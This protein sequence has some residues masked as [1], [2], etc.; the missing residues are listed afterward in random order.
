MRRGLHL[1]GYV[2]KCVQRW[3]KRLRHITLG[4]SWLFL[5]QFRNIQ[6]NDPLKEC[7]FCL[8]WVNQNALSAF[9]SFYY[10]GSLLSE[11]NRH[12]HWSF[13]IPG[14]IFFSSFELP[15]L[16]VWLIYRCGLYMGVEGNLWM[17]NSLFNIKWFSSDKLVEQMQC[18]SLVNRYVVLTSKHHEGWT[19]WRSNVSWNW[20]SVDNGPH[21]D[22]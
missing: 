4:L 12:L 18:H 16:W 3:K 13:N 1:A 5:F 7:N 19:N 17:P 8:F 14:L 10:R 22:G 21:R 6:N 15:E 9:R 20:N 2:L 11:R